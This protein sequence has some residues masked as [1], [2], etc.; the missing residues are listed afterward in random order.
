MSKFQ[1][2]I[3]LKTKYWYD[4]AKVIL[5]VVDE[6]YPNKLCNFGGKMY[7]YQSFLWCWDKNALSINE[8]RRGDEPMRYVNSG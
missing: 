2:H 7:L 8:L 6:L 3:K 5:Y 4:D 1:L